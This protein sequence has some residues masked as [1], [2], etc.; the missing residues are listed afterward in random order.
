VKF[1]R[2]SSLPD[3]GAGLLMTAVVALV[4]WPGFRADWV[5]DDFLVLAFSRLLG[6]PFPLFVQDH[7]HV[8]GAIFRPLGYASQ[9][10]TQAMFGNGYQAHS[11]IELALHVG[12]TR[13]TGL[14]VWERHRATWRCC[15]R[16]CTR[17]IQR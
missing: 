2:A 15:A 14:S 8:P 16:C 3:V 1:T 4:S 17:C 13:F 5:R 10:L 6:T 11:A 12:V 7:F 9:W